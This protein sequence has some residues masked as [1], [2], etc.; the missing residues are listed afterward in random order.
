[1]ALET[2]TY[3]NQLV[4][5]NPNGSDPKGQGDDHLRTIKGALKNTFPNVNGPVN[6]TP[7]QLNKLTDPTLFFIR[8]MVIMWYGNL[9][10]IPSGWRLCDGLDGTPDLRNRFVV[11]AG[12]DYVVGQ[13]G[14]NAL[15]SHN[16]N[17]GFHTLTVAEL[18]P[19]S[20]TIP[21]TIGEEDVR[22]GQKQYGA[23]PTGGVVTTSSSGGNQ[24]HNH[25]G[26]ADNA[27]HRPPFYGLGFLMRL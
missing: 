23:T 12:A 25:P 24:G 3:I 22:G 19:H 13:T 18:P 8:G 16:I 4:P 27:D 26:S 6:A 20:H 17:V 11:G 2:A 9:N 21:E 5:S 14:G 1:M 7:D 15:H 10:A